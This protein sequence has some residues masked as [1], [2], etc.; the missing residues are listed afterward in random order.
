MIY[1]LLYIVCVVAANYT[2]TWFLPVSAFGFISVGTLIFGATFTLRDYAHAMGRR[3][4]YVMI[5]SAIALS[6]LLSVYY[7]VEWRVIA[8]SAIAIGLSEA[9]DTEVYQSLKQKSWIIRVS[10][11][12]AISIPLDTLAFNFLAFWGVFDTSFFVMILAGEI[13][14]KY[15]IG[16]AVGMLRWKTKSYQLT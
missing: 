8:A 9:V 6:T 12:N 7:A 16:F 14:V 11:S 2:A 15:I 4:V 10:S 5:L 13:L 3:V 1:V